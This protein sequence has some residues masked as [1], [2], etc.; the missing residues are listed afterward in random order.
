[1][2]GFL[3]ILILHPIIFLV[4]EEE[5]K[6]F[7]LMQ[8]RNTDYQKKLKILNFWCFKYMVKIEL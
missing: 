4:W 3:N 7:Y 6:I 2:D 8:R 1:M 5:E